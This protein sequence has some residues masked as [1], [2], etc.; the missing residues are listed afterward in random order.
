MKYVNYRFAAQPYALPFGEG[1]PVGGGR[2]QNAPKCSV[3]SC[4]VLPSS[5]SPSGC[6]LPQRGRLWCSANL[7]IIYIFHFPISHNIWLS[8]D[9]RCLLCIFHG[10]SWAG[11]FRG[12]CFP[13]AYR[14]N[15]S[16]NKALPPGGNFRRGPDRFSAERYLHLHFCMVSCIW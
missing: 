3:C 16:N 10:L 4:V 15:K 6:H 8:F 7:P 2:G 1:A 14:C 12:G 9:M 11:P 5:V 13:A